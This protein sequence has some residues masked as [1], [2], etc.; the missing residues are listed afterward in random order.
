[1]Y[2]IIKK[3]NIFSQNVFHQQKT[4]NMFKRNGKK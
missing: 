1:M 2:K 4:P 3:Q